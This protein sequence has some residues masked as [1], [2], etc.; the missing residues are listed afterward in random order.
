MRPGVCVCGEVWGLL[1]VSPRGV[2]R[3]VVPGGCLALG[4]VLGWWPALAAGHNGFGGVLVAG[5]SRDVARCRQAP[6]LSGTRLMRR[7][8]CVTD[9]GSG[10]R[11]LP[12]AQGHLGCVSE[13]LCVGIEKA[14]NDLSSD[15]PLTL[16]SCAALDK[17]LNFSVPPFP[18]LQNGNNNHTTSHDIATNTR[19][20]NCV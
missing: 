4:A 8:Q 5:H 1:C 17:F 20:T 9:C 19:V 16:I 12:Q 15:P 11:L 13:A 3:E 2:W 6:A 14:E 7:P 18:Y 10:G